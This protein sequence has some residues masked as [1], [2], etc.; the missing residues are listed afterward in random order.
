[1]EYFHAVCNT[2]PNRHVQMNS[3]EF[4]H[5]DIC[6]FKAASAAVKVFWSTISK[7]V[8]KFASFTFTILLAIE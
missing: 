8:F 6:N 4:L 3:F 5:L 7:S 2:G 1:M